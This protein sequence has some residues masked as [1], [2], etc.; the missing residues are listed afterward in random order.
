MG[1]QCARLV[2]AEDVGSRDET[3]DKSKGTQFWHEKMRFS[4]ASQSLF[5]AA[6]K[7][8]SGE[9]LKAVR[10]LG[11][12]NCCSSRGYRPLQVAI[13]C[14]HHDLVDLL[15]KAGADINGHSNHTPPPL[16]LAAGNGDKA[17][18]EMLLAH[19]ADLNIGDDLSGETALTRASDRGHLPIVQ[20][21]LSRGSPGFQKL[22][23]Q[24]PRAG[25]RGDGATAL[26]LAALHGFRDVCDKLLGVG[27]DPNTANRVGKMPI[28]CAAGGNH[29]EAAHLL[30]TFGSAVTGQD[31]IGQSPLHIATEHGFFATA[32][33]LIR[34]KADINCRRTDGQLPVHLAAR[35]GHDVLCQLLLTQAAEP[36][37]PD[38][39]GELPFSLAFRE[40][41]VRCCRL[42]LQAGAEVK[43]VD[44]N[45]WSPPY[46]EF[47]PHMHE[48]L[49]SGK[50]RNG[51]DSSREL[52]GC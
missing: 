11:D 29:V 40:S 38:V 18:F 21:A 41:H 3:H 22:L 36:N 12:P 27:A 32:E 6:V 14:G 4:H 31:K 39:S 48:Q 51:D 35:Q 7:G 23:V 52:V 5:D 16:V 47:E 30:L 49:L 28:H 2:K 45:C 25:P 17:L 26:H 34:F 13:C 1:V 19:G 43:A 10:S 50:N 24:R 46:T 37:I 8:D 44:S 42:L 9:A 15:L 33:L 20:L